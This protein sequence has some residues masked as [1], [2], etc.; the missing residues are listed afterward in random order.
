MGGPSSTR[1]FDSLL[2]MAVGFSLFI[3][4]HLA[5][6]AADFAPPRAILADD[7]SQSAGGVRRA[8]RPL[9][10]LH[11]DILRAGD[12]GGA[13]ISSGSSSTIAASSRACA[14]S[15]PAVWSATRPQRGGSMSA[16]RERPPRGRRWLLACRW[17]SSSRSPAFLLRLCGG[18]PQNSVRLDR[19]AGAQTA[20]G[21]KVF[22][23]TARRYP[24]STPP[25]SKANQHRQCLGILCVPC[26]DG[27]RCSGLAKDKRLQ[28]VGINY[29]DAPTTPGP[30][31][32][33]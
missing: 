33:R 3:T 27:R 25:C 24:G 11:R 23:K 12:G 4:L 22:R 5:R 29:K 6:C 20:A 9:H 28:V 16:P 15:K 7:A 18:D 19:P 31:P 8:V 17:P 2:V 10:R 32:L 1:P 21:A 14:N 30:R 26:H 13:V